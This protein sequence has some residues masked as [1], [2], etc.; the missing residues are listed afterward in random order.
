MPWVSSD[1]KHLYWF[2]AVWTG[3]FIQPLW[4]DRDGE[5]LLAQAKVAVTIS[6]LICELIKVLLEPY[7]YMRIIMG[8]RI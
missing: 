5:S 7:Q 4:T 2:M 6:Q 3:K 8:I 1:A